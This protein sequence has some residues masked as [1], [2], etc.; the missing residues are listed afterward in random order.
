MPRECSDIWAVL[1][2]DHAVRRAFALV[3]ASIASVQLSSLPLAM[4]K[5]ADAFA[6]ERPAG[7]AWVYDVALGHQASPKL[8]SDVPPLHSDSRLMA[9]SVVSAE[10]AH[11]LGK[12]FASTL[13]SVLEQVALL[14][15]SLP[16]ANIAT[17]SASSLDR[18]AELTA[19]FEQKRSL[20]ASRAQ[21]GVYKALSAVS[22]LLYSHLQALESEISIKRM[23][24]ALCV[25]FFAPHF[26]SNGRMRTGRTLCVQTA[27]AKRE[28]I[29]LPLEQALC[30]SRTAALCRVHACSTMK[31][32][33]RY[34]LATWRGEAQPRVRS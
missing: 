24:V 32:S 14:S 5:V 31:A 12:S 27:E 6:A 10:Q 25:P 21:N 18:T 13:Q 26:A 19:Y 20:I 28:T 11:R 4:E 29:L 33:A 17:D 1:F 34:R 22:K 7:I 3:D 15:S 30:I 9:S 23:E 8:G 16:Q 2:H